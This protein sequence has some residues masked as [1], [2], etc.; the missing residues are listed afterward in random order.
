MVSNILTL[1]QINF[2]AIQ[3]Q[4]SE[5]VYFPKKENQKRSSNILCAYSTRRTYHILTIKLFG[6]LHNQ[7]IT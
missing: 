4:M 2:K 1:P 6:F 7:S 3:Y 5:L